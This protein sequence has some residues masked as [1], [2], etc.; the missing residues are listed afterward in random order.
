MES[1]DSVVVGRVVGKSVVRAMVLGSR[2]VWEVV[3]EASVVVGGS[4]V[5]G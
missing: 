2:V 1:L 3:G 5:T 4:M